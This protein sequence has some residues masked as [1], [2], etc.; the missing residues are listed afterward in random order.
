[1]SLSCMLRPRGRCR[2]GN[3][4]YVAPNKGLRIFC[5]T[6]PLLFFGTPSDK[7]LIVKAYHAPHQPVQ[8]KRKLLG[9]PPT[10]QFYHLLSSFVTCP[11]IVCVCMRK[12]SLSCPIM[13]QRHRI[14]SS[15]FTCRKY[16]ISKSRILTI[17]APFRKRISPNTE[18]LISLLQGEIV[19]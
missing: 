10:Y 8:G 17:N 18:R 13:V 9:E 3:K 4:P 15:S 5:E 6:S 12:A 19:E 2:L 7:S 14:K 16:F 1:M 11:I